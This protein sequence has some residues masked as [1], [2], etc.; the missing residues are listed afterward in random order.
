MFWKAISYY[1]CQINIVCV[2]V[3]IS[4]IFSPEMFFVTLQHCDILTRQEMEKDLWKTHQDTITSNI[5]NV[6]ILGD[7]NA[8][9]KDFNGNTTNKSGIAL[10]LLDTDNLT[11]NNDEPTNIHSGHAGLGALVTRSLSHPPELQCE[12]RHWQRPPPHARHFLPQLQKKATVTGKPTG[13]TLSN[14]PRTLLGSHTAT[15]ARP[16]GRTHWINTHPGT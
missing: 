9:H 10:D 6:L 8:N 13:N 11:I 5:K 12:P 2:N 1:S 3:V 7:F 15:A 16:P 4:T 14:K